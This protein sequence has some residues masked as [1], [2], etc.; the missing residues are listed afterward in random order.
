MDKKVFIIP[1]L[2]LN[3]CF[4]TIIFAE[5]IL[6][7]SGKTVEGK[8]I[9]KTDEYIKIDFQGV[10]LTYFFDEI[11]NING[12]KVANLRS[13]VN[14]EESFKIDQPSAIIPV[15]KENTDKVIATVYD[16]KIFMSEK[17]NLTG[18][19][20]GTLLERYADDHNIKPTQEEIDE[21]LKSQEKMELRRKEEWENGRQEILRKLQS[22][23][24]AESERSSLTSH[25]KVLDNLLKLDPKLEQYRQE[26]PEQV[27]KMH[28][29]IA[30]AVIRTWK[31]N[32][33]LFD[34][35]GGRVIF[36]QAGPE[37]LDAYLKFLKEQEKKGSFKILDKSFSEIFWKYF[38][39]DKTHTFIS[40]KREEG[41]KIFD[42]P[43]WLADNK[44]NRQ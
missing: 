42:T 33:A 14:K 39:D 19:I 6:L 2:I 20:F 17:N 3:L 22:N 40:Q 4:P 11:E 30:M 12:E 41:A 27:K 10:S 26:N 29:Q 9:K 35:Y 15:A 8:L 1:L 34:Q 24:L 36:Q 16:R 23:T 43:W 37:P 44:W 32:K 7:K 28:E 5:T 18:I 38:T 13:P 25:L 31:T 21:F